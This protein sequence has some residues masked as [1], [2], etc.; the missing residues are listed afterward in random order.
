MNS[1]NRGFTLIELLVS[2]AIIATLI[3]L[4]LPAVQSAREAAR[5]TQC[6]NNLK[7][8]A[9]SAHNYH[10][11][12]QCFPLNITVVY[13]QNCICV[14][15][16]GIAGC[17]NDFNMHTWGAQLLP[18]LE[19]NTVYSRI[20]QNSP[21][22]SPASIC[23]G[24]NPTSYTSLN[25]GCPCSDPCAM[26]RP[27]AAVIP[28]FV[29]PSAPRLQNPFVE[30]TQFWN[31][32]LGCAFQFTRTSGASD[33]QVWCKYG[34]F[35]GCA[36]NYLST[37]SIR[38][39]KDPCGRKAVFADG[40]AKRIDDII[41]GASTTIFCTELAGR[42]SYWTRSP[43]VGGLVNHCLPT[44]CNP[45]KM[46]QFT[47]STP[48]G[49]WGC[50]NNGWMEVQGSLFTGA[51]PTSI[52]AP[53]CIFN[54]TNEPQ[55]NLVFSFHPGTGGVVMCDGSAHMLSENMSMITLF[56]LLTF[57]GREPVTD[58]F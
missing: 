2:I 42:P 57:N 47:T 4:L 15:Q 52:S 7:Q 32:C 11:A 44:P 49:C 29:C 22:F 23:V 21:L 3:S 54:C 30:K 16:T 19:G 17:Y 51:R 56:N 43:S 37:G 20:D 40:S 1:R 5:R 36:Y 41:D 55:G 6:R 18:Y 10:D 38:C 8:V 58:G 45:T 46:Y 9:L 14:C 24:S 27:I 48:G 34:G 35:A 28:T 39:G 13:N 33:M 25:S 53:I 12:N 50:F 31:C 26:A